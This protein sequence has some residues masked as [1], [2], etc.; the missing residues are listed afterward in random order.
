MS[1]TNK[2]EKCKI[3]NREFSQLSA[4]RK[5]QSID[6]NNEG[7]KLKPFKCQICGRHFA[8]K[9]TVQKHM[10]THTKEKPWK[11][12][13]CGRKFGHKSSWKRHIRKLHNKKVV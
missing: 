5:H 3:C 1:T 2:P 7:L 12:D 10:V 6:H 8:R 4:L 9:D 13:I 11:C